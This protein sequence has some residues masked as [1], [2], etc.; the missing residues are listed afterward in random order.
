[1]FAANGFGSDVSEIVFTICAL[2]AWVAW[3]YFK[4]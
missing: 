1:M 3:L 4:R 2:I